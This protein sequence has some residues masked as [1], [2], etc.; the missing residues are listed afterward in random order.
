MDPP[1]QI[2]CEVGGA[3]CAVEHN[4]HIDARG[5][6]LEWPKAAVKSDGIYFTI[7]CPNCGE[8]SQR[9]APRPKYDE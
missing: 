9:I 5:R 2:P 6:R 4:V 8:R 3:L 1:A 7:I